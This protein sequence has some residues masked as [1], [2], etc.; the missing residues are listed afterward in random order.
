MKYRNIPPNASILFESLRGLGYSIESALADI[1]DNSIAANAKSVHVHFEWAESQSWI[2]ILDDGLGMTDPELETAM[3][4]GARD[5]RDNRD[6][7][8]L[9]RFGMG[10]KTASFSLG[11]RLTV[12]SKKKN[13]PINALCW[14]LD[15]LV[16]QDTTWSLQDI[17]EENYHSALSVMNQKQCGTI[18]LIENLDRIIVEGFVVENLFTIINQI[19]EYLGMIF[20]RYL[21]GSDPAL[22][23]HING[24]RVKP[25]DPFLTGHAGK[26]QETSPLKIGR[27][28]KVEIQ[29]HVLPHKDLLT[30]NENRLASG[31]Y[32]WV[33]QQGFYVYRNKRLIVPGSW[34]NLGDGRQTWAKD[35][36]YRLA[37]IRVDLPNTCDEEWNINITKSAARPPINLR[38]FLKR[39]G[40]NTRAIARNVLA[41]RGVLVPTSDYSA[42]STDALPSVWDAR[43]GT[44]GTTFH[45][46]RKHILVKS[47]L[48]NG[49]SS[50]ADLKA[51]LSLIEETVPAHHVWVDTAQEQETQKDEFSSSSDENV[52]E[53][54]NALY[55]IQIEQYGLSPNVAKQKLR[56]TPP[57]QKF[58]EIIEKLG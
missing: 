31:T 7:N 35:E 41:S 4:L 17:A 16:K 53:V 40:S 29:G 9:G 42:A 19:S 15:D 33:T 34:L 48:D 1:V 30:E 57:F 45:I 27:T 51:L 21:E 47:I 39:I 44:R 52:T 14:D 10:L 50:S 8:D 37:R 23:L 46:N 26:A 24:N 49:A 28:H 18:V 11:K 13:N 12:T 38:P 36:Q 58:S 6:A 56:H 43:Q 5:P 54:L 20:H 22:A 3:R 32:G 2:R 25:W 55:R